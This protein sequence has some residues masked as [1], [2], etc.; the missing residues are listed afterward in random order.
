MRIA[1]SVPDKH[2]WLTPEA[3]AALARLSRRWGMND[4]ATIQEA[5][6]RALDSD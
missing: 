1:S 5:L 3:V 4:S 2:I 6:K